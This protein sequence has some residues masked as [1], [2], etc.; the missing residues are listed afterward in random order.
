M[1]SSRWTIWARATTP[2]KKACCGCGVPAAQTPA[3][4]ILT[5]ETGAAPVRIRAEELARMLTA[6]PQF[7]RATVQSVL[8]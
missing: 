1:G 3:K 7:A 2:R 6:N 5:D 8:V 4:F